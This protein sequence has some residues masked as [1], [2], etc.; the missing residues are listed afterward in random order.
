MPYAPGQQYDFRPLFE[1]IRSLGNNIGDAVQRY[2]KDKQESQFLDA[3]YEGLAQ[4]MGAMDP[5]RAEDLAK[6]SGLSLAQKR[7][8][9]AS[10]A[11]EFNQMQKNQDR[12]LRERGVA[13]Q[14]R[15]VSLAEAAQQAGLAARQRDEEAA[16]GFQG[17]LAE[18]MQGG[19]LADGFREPGQ[20][21]LADIVSA[22]GSSGYRLPPGALMDAIRTSQVDP[23]AQAPREFQVGGRAGVYSPRT[24]A[25]DLLPQDSLTPGQKQTAAQNLQRQWVDITKAMSDPTAQNMD[26]LKQARQMLE[27]Q[28]A[29]YGLKPPQRNA[30]PAPDGAATAK[31]DGGKTL[32]YSPGRGKLIPQ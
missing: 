29:F 8:K 32:L 30:A 11:F 21:S 3:Q 5:G 31:Q 22:A 12:A 23:E 13:A 24:G 14:E 1:G 17:R 7:G 18:I 15:Q 6:F 20:L 16:T 26:E 19:P 27:D 28:F 10:L 2:Q 25:F 9:A 4:T